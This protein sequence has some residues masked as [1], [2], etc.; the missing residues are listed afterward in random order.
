M[1]PVR[2]VQQEPSDKHFYLCQY[3]GSA[4][5][6]FWIWS[7]VASV[8]LLTRAGLILQIRGWFTFRYTF[9]LDPANPM[10]HIQGFIAPRDQTLTLCSKKHIR[11][12]SNLLGTVSC[13]RGQKQNKK[14]NNKKI[15]NKANCLSGKTSILM[16]IVLLPKV[17]LSHIL[18]KHTKYLRVRKHAQ[19]RARP[20][21]FRSILSELATEITLQLSKRKKRR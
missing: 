13:K 18:H 5:F 3:Y 8:L 19:I 7:V 6:K 11:S 9:K 4:V 14:Q 21:L 2:E 17:Q 15:Q 20:R 12:S 10:A 1:L 16:Q